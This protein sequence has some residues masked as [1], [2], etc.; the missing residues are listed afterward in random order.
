[1]ESKPCPKCGLI[2][3]LSEFG[4]HSRT[5]DGLQA[6]CKACKQ[7]I[8]FECQTL[9]SEITHKKCKGPC[10]ETK[11]VEN[12]I[13]RL[14]RGD[15]YESYCKDCRLIIAKEKQANFSA[16][17]KW[18]PGCERDKS[19]ME[20]NKNSRTRDGL[21]SYC[22]PCRTTMARNYARLNPKKN[23][24]RAN[25]YRKKHPEKVKARLDKWREGNE[26][27]IKEYEKDYR[28]KHKEHRRE[29]GYLR[30]YGITIK[31]K[32]DMLK[33][34]GGNCLLCGKPIINLS[35]NNMCIDH[36]H[37]TDGTSGKIRG[38]L[39]G[40]CNLFLGHSNED[41][42]MARALLAYILNHCQ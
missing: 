23:R 26:S 35:G 7:K 41:P 31:E 15:G 18:C 5:K 39:H 20:F 19:V 4:I 2:K 3:D 8:Q 29:D 21:Q 24:D 30:R 1:M 16:T 40:K 36:K 6:D 9:M 13:K 28:E 34:Q 42:E 14:G 12:F 37:T 11:A 17:T 27:H 22:N 32:E 33:S 25:Q 10:G 38:I